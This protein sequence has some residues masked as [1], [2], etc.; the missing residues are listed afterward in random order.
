MNSLTKNFGSFLLLSG[1]VAC[2]GKAI[3]DPVDTG[4]AGANS[5]AGGSSSQSSSS[6]PNG[7]GGQGAGAGGLG[8]LRFEDADGSVVGGAVALAASIAV[9]VP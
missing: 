1:A 4:G 6:S 2:G 8:R 7:S 3:I 5:G 9:F